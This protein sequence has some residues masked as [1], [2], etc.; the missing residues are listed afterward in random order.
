MEV[1]LEDERRQR[2]LAL[3]SKKKLETDLA[4]LE[5][6]IDAANKG[7]DDALKQLKKLQVKYRACIYKHN[8]ECNTETC[9]S[10]IRLLY[11]YR[12]HKTNY[13]PLS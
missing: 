8:T 10:K 6:Q 7:R 13:R 12:C 9:H 1:E 4:D 11:T 2:A 5:A 3:S